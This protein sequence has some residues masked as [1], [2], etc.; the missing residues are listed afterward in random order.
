MAV[1]SGRPVTVGAKGDAPSILGPTPPP[2][3]PAP[4]DEITD[5]RHPANTRSGYGM[6]G[7]SGAASLPPG[8]QKLSPMAENL[9]A[10]SESSEGLTLDHIIQHGTARDSTVDLMSPQTRPYSSDQKVPT[11]F[12]HHKPSASGTVPSVTGHSPMADEARRRADRRI[13]Q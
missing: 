1:Q 9:K 3:R 8:Q 6:N 10:S 13:V 11:T 7:Y 4:P 5:M 2:T 12:G